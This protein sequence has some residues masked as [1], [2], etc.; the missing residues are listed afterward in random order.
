M[1][2]KKHMIVMFHD[3]QSDFDTEYIPELI[4]RARKL[5]LP[6]DVCHW[7]SYNLHETQIIVSFQG[8]TSDA[9]TIC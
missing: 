7:L 1:T 2:N 3:L 6:L 9:R 5:G 8:E 4:N